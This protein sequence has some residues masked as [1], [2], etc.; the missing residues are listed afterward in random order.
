MR[1]GEIPVLIVRPDTPDDAV[2]LRVRVDDRLHDAP[3]ILRTEHRR[4]RIEPFCKRR[5]AREGAR[6]IRD[7]SFRMSRRQRVGAHGR[8]IELFVGERHGD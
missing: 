3:D 7:L 1:T 8:E 6:K 5:P 4:E 2:A